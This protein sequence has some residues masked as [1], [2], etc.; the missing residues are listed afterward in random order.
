MSATSSSAQPSSITLARP[1][2][3]ANGKKIKLQPDMSLRTDIILEKRTLA[4]WIL[5]PIRHLRIEG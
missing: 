3:D 4:D 5:A 1:D 2:V